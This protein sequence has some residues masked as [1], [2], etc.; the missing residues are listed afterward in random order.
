MYSSYNIF[1]PINLLF[2]NLSSDFSK[3][4]GDWH[5][6]LNQLSNYKLIYKLKTTEIPTNE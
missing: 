2:Y 6:G 3:N 4:W 1:L 5:I